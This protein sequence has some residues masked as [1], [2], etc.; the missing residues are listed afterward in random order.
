MSKLEFSAHFSRIEKMFRIQQS[1]YQILQNC[2]TKQENTI[3]F[4]DI[5]D[6]NVCFIGYSDDKKV[7]D[8]LPKGHCS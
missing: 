2:P 6:H 5:W 1:F 7:I 4:I 8:E 3:I